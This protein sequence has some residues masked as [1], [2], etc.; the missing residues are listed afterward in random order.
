MITRSQRF[1]AIQ[2]SAMANAAGV[3]AQALLIA[4]LGPLAPIQLAN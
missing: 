3:D 2:S 4:K 1:V